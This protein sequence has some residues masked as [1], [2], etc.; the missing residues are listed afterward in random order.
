MS[1]SL[2]IARPDDVL[3]QG[4]Y[5]GLQWITMRNRLGYRCGYVR[6]PQGHPWHS[7]DCDEIPAAVHGGLTFT[8]D[9]V[10]CDAP[11]DD[12]AYWI[13]FDCAHGGDR[14]DP[15]LGGRLSPLDFSGIVRDQ[16]YVEAECWNLCAQAYEAGIINHEEKG[17]NCMSD[18]IIIDLGEG[19]ALRFEYYPTTT[20]VDFLSRHKDEGARFEVDAPC[21]EQ[22]AEA[23]YTSPMLNE[24]RQPPEQSWEELKATLYKFET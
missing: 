8:E 16:A 24:E 23:L 3:S 4:E 19:R 12:N 5:A 9:D 1:L 7:M 22:I 17:D 6:L 18:A 10:P 13:G 11:G 20:V 15:T 14:A 21:G 2:V